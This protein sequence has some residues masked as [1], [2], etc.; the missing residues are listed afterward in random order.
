[1]TEVLVNL[2]H[3]HQRPCSSSFS[4]HPG[5]TLGEPSILSLGGVTSLRSYQH[6]S[7]TV[8]P[9]LLQERLDTAALMM[10]R[11]SETRMVGRKDSNAGRGIYR[12]KPPLNFNNIEYCIRRL[13]FLPIIPPSKSTSIPRRALRADVEQQVGLGTLH[14]RHEQINSRKREQLQL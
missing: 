7:A 4:F 14:L 2:A 10:P 12:N 6:C 3:S 8:C 11:G 1:M 13:Q 5:L 9:S